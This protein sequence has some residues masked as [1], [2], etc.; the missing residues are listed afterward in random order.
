MLPFKQVGA[1]VSVSASTTSART[2]LSGHT[3][4]WWVVNIGSVA[5]FVH[6]GDGSVTATAADTPIPPNAGV[7]IQANPASSNAAAI[8]ATGT[9]TVYVAPVQPRF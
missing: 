3:G 1:T 4:Y 2:A 8:T 6:F 7:L 5:A 9:A